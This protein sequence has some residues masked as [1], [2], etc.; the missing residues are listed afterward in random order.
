MD[1][2]FRLTSPTDFRRVRR[3]GTSYAHPLVVLVISSNQLDRPRFGV[4][5]SRSLRKATDRNR[6]KRR[7]RHAL[8]PHVLNTEPG[9]DLVFIARPAI[10]DAPW[11]QLTGAVRDLLKR[12][13]TLKA[14]KEE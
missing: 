13:G 10:L 11:G 1:R 14:V 6:A 9:W 3:K 12:S 5:T 8:R 2:D 4:T 7:L